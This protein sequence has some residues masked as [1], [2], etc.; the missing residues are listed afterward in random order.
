MI[1]TQKEPEKVYHAMHDE[2]DVPLYVAQLGMVG[3]HVKP[4]GEYPAMQ[5]VQYPAFVSQPL[6]RELHGPQL[7]LAVVYKA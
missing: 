6:Q 7:K 5:P 3:T 2:H 4:E 1:G